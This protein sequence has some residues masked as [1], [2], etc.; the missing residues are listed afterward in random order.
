MWFPFTSRPSSELGRQMAITAPP[1]NGPFSIRRRD[2]RKK[3]RLGH[4]KTAC[5]KN[6]IR[7]GQ[8]Q[9]FPVHN[10]AI[11]RNA[12]SPSKIR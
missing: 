11:N 5:R 4:S 7:A 10:G 6:N 3:N 8:Q 1:I 12:L 2:G 9:H